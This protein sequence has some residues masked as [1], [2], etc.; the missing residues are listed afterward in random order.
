MKIASDRPIIDALL[1]LAL[2]GSA[3]TISFRETIELD[4]EAPYVHA[5]S[6]STEDGVYGTGDELRLVCLF[7]QPVVVVGE[8]GG[9]PSIGLSLGRDVRDSRAVYS[10][11]NGTNEFEFSYT[12]SKRGRFLR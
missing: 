7:S 4:T 2:P 10:G 1:V 12:V 9:T 5:V 11:G 6:V 8:D 3:G